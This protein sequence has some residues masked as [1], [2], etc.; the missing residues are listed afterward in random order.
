MQ[1]VLRKPILSPP[2]VSHVWK[3]ES[4]MY[5]DRVLCGAESLDPYPH[6]SIFLILQFPFSSVLL[7]THP[8]PFPH[9][10]PCSTNNSISL[11]FP[12]LQPC[13]LCT[14][15]IL[16]VCHCSWVSPCAGLHALP[17]SSL[18]LPSHPDPSRHLDWLMHLQNWLTYFL[19]IIHCYYFLS[20]T[21]YHEKYTKCKPC[22]S[23]FNCQIQE[24]FSFLHRGKAL[25][26]TVS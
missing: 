13:P 11:H 7:L 26:C 4:L 3:L 23:I 18:T 12:P 21:W 22:E 14:D 16:L 24:H 8:P 19:I 15:A 25:I 1:P 9:L 6:L 10:H 20:L 17:R 5:Q 2:S